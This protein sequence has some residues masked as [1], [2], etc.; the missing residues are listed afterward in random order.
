MSAPPIVVATHEV[1]NQP[2]PLENLNVFEQDVALRTAVAREGG[3]WGEA[4]LNR[5]GAWLGQAATLRLGEQANRNPPV[6]RSH[7]RFGHRIDEVDFA[8]AW[9]E[10]MRRAIAEQIH[11]LPWIDQRPGAHVVR[12]ASAFLL[13]QVESGVCCPI[14]MTFAALPA[15]RAAP[16]IAEAWAAKILSAEYDPSAQPVAA[17]KGALIGMAMTEKQG[18]SDLRAGTT[19]AEPS[20]DGG[21]R[22]LGH[23]WFCSA[24]TSDA[25]LTL[26]WTEAGLS[27]FFVPRWRPDG[28]RNAIHLQRLKDKLGNRANASAEIEYAGASAQLVGEAGQGVRTIIKMVHHTRLDAAVSSAALMRQAVAQA[29]HHAAHRSAFEKRLIDQPLMRNV[30]ADLA[31]ESE[32]ATALVMRLARTFDAAASDPVAASFARLATA[33]T[34]FWVCKRAPAAIAEALECLGGN[35]YVE[36]S[37]LP[38]LYREAPVNSVWE[39]S[40]NVVCLDALRTLTRDP[41]ALEAV[42]AELDRVRGADLRLDAWLVRLKNCLR[43]QA[44]GEP[45]VR[46]LV[47]HLALA[48][49][50]A[51]LVEHAP[52]GVAD[53]FC[54]SR[55]ADGCGRQ[56]GAL[57]RGLDLALICERARPNLT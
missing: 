18:G 28:T 23:K 51:L 3:A 24:P 17:K 22:L 30:L 16:Q 43:E 45:Q 26:A 56:F 41:A 50:A 8:P 13:N 42:L 47:E 57:P 31:L 29:L 2:P 38:R 19:R 27:C 11:A 54:A 39:G 33:V 37:I 35:G 36:E 20:G 12:A 55:L 9:H 7:D 6:L 14:A 49:Q 32:A 21:Y 25:F 52:A 46:R 4:R 40:G 5:F 53:A 48:L 1:L 44:D 34:K 15:L 10:L